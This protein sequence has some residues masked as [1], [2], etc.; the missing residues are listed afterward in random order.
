MPA[1]KAAFVEVGQ[2]LSA[3]AITGALLPYVRVRKTA[4]TIVID[5]YSYMCL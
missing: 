4:V 1:F 5:T 3:M 2:L